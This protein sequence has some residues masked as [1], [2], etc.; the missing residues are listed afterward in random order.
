MNYKEKQDWLKEKYPCTVVMDRYSGTYSDAEFL[1]FPLDFN[2]VPEDVNGDDPECAYF[3]KNY[4][5]PVGKGASALEA[6]DDLIVKMKDENEGIRKEIIQHFQNIL[7]EGADTT[8][9]EDTKRWLA[10]LEKQKE[11]EGY[12]AIPVESTLEYKLGFKAGK[13]FGK[14]QKQKPIKWTDLTWKD[15]VELEGIINNVHYDFSAGIGQES[16]GKEVLERFRSTKGIEY[17]DEAEQKYWRK[18]EQKEPLP[19]PDKFSGLKSLMLQYLQSAANR[20]D[21][22]EIENDT[23][24]FGR[25]ILDYVWKYSDEQKEQKPADLPAGF[26]VTLDGKKYYTKEIHCKGMNV[27]VVEPKPAEWSEEDEKHIN[28]ILDIIDYWK[29]TMHFVSYQEGTI[30]AD[31]D[32]LKSLRPQ[33]KWKPTEEQLNCLAMTLTSEAM[34]DNVHDVLSKLYA[35]L[36]KQME[37]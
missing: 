15:I 13:E 10:Y 34:D 11:E 25:K 6:I 27:K 4:K 7:K 37:E 5:E 12:E 19:I 33:P 23:D 16:F 28:N 21:D 3:W 14:Q 32:W 8:T 1:A 22:T 31:I 2:E 18:D 26:Y 36:K 9:M 17:L 30:D 35:D 29:A 20:K 24:L